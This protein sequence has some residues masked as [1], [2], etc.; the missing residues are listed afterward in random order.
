MLR[1]AKSKGLKLKKGWWK[2]LKPD[3]S[4]K[5]NPSHRHIWRLS[6]EER[7]ICEGSKIHRSVFQR[8]DNPDNGYTPASTQIRVI[9]D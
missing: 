9:V 4:G 8:K 1:H 6:T 2:C 5:I 7:R 3:P